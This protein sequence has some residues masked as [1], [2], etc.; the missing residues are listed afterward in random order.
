MDLAFNEEIFVDEDISS[1]IS[2]KNKRYQASL[3][4]FSP[5]RNQVGLFKSALDKCSDFFQYRAIG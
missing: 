1:G 2:Y 4:Y 3:S 5:D